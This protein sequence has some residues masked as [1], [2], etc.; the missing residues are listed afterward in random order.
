MVTGCLIVLCTL[1]L[2]S[3]VALACHVCQLKKHV[4]ND[5]DLIS[6]HEYWIGTAQRNGGKPETEA[7]ESSILM[8]HFKPSETQEELSASAAEE[9][10][11]KVN[12][13]GKTGEEAS[14]TVKEGGDAAA[15]SDQTSASETK[16]DTADAPSTEA[17][18]ASSSEGTEEPKDAV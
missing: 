16:T 15:A 14:E 2:V 5:A 6:N 10:A 4:H 8:S 3:T 7:G 1:L 11:E 18:A 12:E 9:D 17:T 13:D